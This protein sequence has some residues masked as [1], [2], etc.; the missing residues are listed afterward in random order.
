[1]E[2]LPEESH[3]TSES[4]T[5]PPAPGRIQRVTNETR[6]LAEDLTAWV[7]LKA[8]HT[9][10][11]IEETVELKLNHAV[12]G[13]IVAIVGAVAAL[14]LLVTLAIGAGWL[15]GH[16]F[17]GFLVVTVVLFVVAGVVRALQPTLIR[18]RAERLGIDAPPPRQDTSSS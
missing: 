11:E 16:P 13:V 6:G 18:L 9:Q 14:F 2:S 1:M 8:R 17:W 10:M 7:E 12:V 5:S 4:L 15:L 3:G